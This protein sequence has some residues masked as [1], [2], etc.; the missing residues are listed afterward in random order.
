MTRTVPL[1]IGLAVLALTGALGGL[2]SGYVAYDAATVLRGLAGTGDPAATAIV[3][4]VRLP[5]VLL[6]LEVGA[7][8]GL[9]GAA[10]QGLLRNPLAEPGLIGVSASAG[11]GAVVAFYF[12]LGALGAWTVPAAA[13]TGAAAATAV[14]MAVAVR[15]AGNLTLILTGIA[16]SSLAVALTSLA[17]NLAPDPYALSEMVLWLLGSLKDR[18]LD[19]AALA[20]PFIAAGSLLLLGTGRGL[21]ALTLGEE[22][23]RT[24]GINLSRLRL[25]VIAG[26]AMAVGAAV[27]VAG[28]IG[29]V[30]LVV[31]HL[32]RPL[33]G[34]E[35]S[36]LLL[37]SALG[38][39]TLVVTADVAARSLP[40][41]QEVNLGVVTALIGAPFFLVLILRMQRTMT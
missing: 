13:M 25:T 21:D 10:L 15:G 3:R 18:S 17:M 29:F 19:D 40:T 12:G 34:Y 36:R 1:L 31:P 7:A 38:G 22:T 41:A 24:L 35:P 26:T 2:M 37:P 11:L 27:A 30:G 23:A 16:V 5:R 8:L 6:G 9:A 33:V 14:L 32:L 39:A 28:T 4:E 20:L